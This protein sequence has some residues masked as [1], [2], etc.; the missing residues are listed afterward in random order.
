MAPEDA[1]GSPALCWCWLREE[2]AD[3]RE[4]CWTCCWWEEESSREIVDGLL[5][6]DAVTA[7][8]PPP[9]PLTPTRSLSVAAPRGSTSLVGL[10][11]DSAVNTEKCNY[12]RITIRSQKLT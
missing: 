4:C 5:D 11:P 6:E 3:D 12:M 9:P 1:A 10:T 8:E 7:E 2:D